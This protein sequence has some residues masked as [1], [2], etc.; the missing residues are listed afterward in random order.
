MVVP[1]HL[2]N[3]ACRE[4]D[5]GESITFRLA[6]PCGC[7]QFICLA[8]AFSPEEKA[9][10]A[11][12]LAALGRYSRGED[13]LLPPRPA[14]LPFA[15]LAAVCAGCGARHMVF[16]SR[17][18]GYDGWRGLEEDPDYPAAFGAIPGLGAGELKLE[19]QGEAT[20]EAYREAVSDPRAGREEW[21]ESFVELKAWLC[22][23][24]GE[25]EVLAW[26]IQ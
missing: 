23:P 7:R 15:A 21:S 18:H 25:R 8:P 3:L 20:L 9:A 22:T 1:A 14:I 13:V 10:M 6:C 24:E 19:A 16:D 5:R 4:E 17:R 26:E 11:P 12:F 2:K